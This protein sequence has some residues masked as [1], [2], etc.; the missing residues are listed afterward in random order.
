MTPGPDTKL[1]QQG[2]YQA[3]LKQ[4]KQ[5]Q[6]ITGKHRTDKTYKLNK[7]TTL[8]R[9]LISKELRERD[10]EVGLKNS[11]QSNQLLAEDNVFWIKKGLR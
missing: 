6:H 5:Q 1:S 2:G 7:Y 9:P 3:N 10:T 4:T 11:K 8:E